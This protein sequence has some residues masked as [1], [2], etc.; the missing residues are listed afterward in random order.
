MKNKHPIVF[1]LLAL[2]MLV[3]G[4]VMP[5]SLG[6]P[7][8]AQAAPGMLKWSTVDTPGSFSDRAD[9]ALRSE[10]DK[11]V[12]GPK[13]TTLLAVVT[14]NTVPAMQLYSS[15]SSGRSWG[16][17][18]RLRDAML[19]EW[20][21]FTNVWDAAIAPDDQKFWAVATSSPTIDGPVEVW[22]T[23]DGGTTWE[24]TKL[25]LTA[26]FIS[27]IDIS[28]RYAGKRDILVGTR[29][30]SGFGTAKLWVRNSTSFSPWRDQSDPAT[31]DPGNT[32]ANPGGDVVAAKFSPTYASD[33]SIVAV[34]S[35]APTGTP[36]GTLLTYGIHDLD[37]NTTT[38]GTPIEVKDQASAP[39]ASPDAATIVTAD[40]ELP[41]DFSGQAASLRRAYV[42]FYSSPK[43]ATNQNGIYRIDDNVVYVLMNATNVTRK[44]ISSIAYV[45]TYAS[46]KLLAGE[47]FGDPCTATV[48]TWFT[49]SP[50]VC[51][52]PCWYPALKPTT[53]AANQGTCSPNSKN[54]YGNAQV[55]WSSDGILA[56]VGTGSACLGTFDTPDDSI[57]CAT[58]EWPDGYLNWVRWDESAFGISRNNGETWN[59]LGLI[60]TT[61][62]QFTDVAPSPDCKTI[63]LASVNVDWEQQMGCDEFDS[64]WRSSSNPAVESPLSAMPV[65]T[66]WERVFTHV[67]AVTCTETQ[68]DIALLR[69]VPYCAD[70]EGQIV[71]WAAWGT[72]AQAWSPDFGDYW[73]MIVPR[74]NIQD[75]CFESATILYNLSPAGLVQKLPYTGTAWSTAL[76][77]VD[78]YLG[79]FL[80]AHTIAAYPEGKVLVGAGFLYHMNAYAVSYC[81]NFNTDSPL[82]AVQAFAG[83]TPYM[84]NV[85]VAFDPNFKDNNTYFICDGIS[86]TSELGSVYR[87][88]PGMMTRWQDVDMMAIANGAIGCDAPDQVWQFGL[89]IAFTGEALYSA[90]MIAAPDVNSGVCR[91]ID[92]GTGNYGPFSGM[93]KPGIAWD[94]LNTFV[95]ATT[96]GVLF[97]LEP[98]SLKA[99]GCCTT[100]TDTTLYAIDNREYNP[101]DRMGMLWEYTDCLAKKGPKLITPDKT[102][103]GCDPVSGRAQEVNFCWEQLCLADQYDIEIAKDKDFSI[104]VIDWTTEA[105]C[106]G[107][108]PADVTKP[109]AYFPAGGRANWYEGSA[110]ALWGNLECGHTYYWRVKVR[111][112]ATGQDI[113]S[114]WSDVRSFTVKAGLPA[115]TPYYGIQLLSPNNGGLGCPVKPASFS[116]SPFKGTAKYKFVLAKDAAMTQLVKEATVTTTAFEYD[117]TLDYSSSYFWRVMS[118]EPVPS[119]WSATFSFQTGTPSAPPVS[120]VPSKA[121]FWDALAMPA[122]AVLN[123]I[124]TINF[125][126]TPAGPMPLWFP[127]SIIVSIVLFILWLLVML[128]ISKLIGKPFGKIRRS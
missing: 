110:I 70:P 92:D 128:A 113:R 11:L 61:I 83:Q 14:R 118:L 66:Y 55:C 126:L 37:A 52:I 9:I 45:G 77:S 120:Q 48:P 79:S 44:N 58:P 49:D 102:L 39:G 19:E 87:G 82:F 46:G 84:G 5:A 40:L 63:Y 65:G 30:G 90:H 81:A 1:S 35:A 100:A 98:T 121:G 119:D 96:A 27:C 80:D 10:I 125:Q 62:V 109:C 57:N 104:L 31:G 127:V 89:V 7:A 34:Y 73:A 51:P 22:V 42:S 97:A 59:Q 106:G 6:N 64:V 12:V 123:W 115:S 33:G 68:T 75:F 69:T 93:P 54:G 94:C 13:G 103:I 74:D 16:G 3:A 91:T 107:F 28:M 41:S 15:G 56:F 78:T 111:H 86:P 122:K 18:S 95:P 114:P 76:P 71:A 53:G 26:D 29:D 101:D 47:V 50:T 24:N 17:T 38:W 88:T 116:W 23:Q 124:A 8:P 2:F 99:C 25:G 67:T 105:V 21:V 32:W 85:H 36:P 60:D 108:T 72:R 4:L 117:G 20:G 112:G 43:N